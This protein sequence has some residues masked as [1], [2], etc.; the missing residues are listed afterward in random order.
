MESIDAQLFR[1]KDKIEWM[2][3]LREEGYVVI[4]DILDTE[5][6]VD[7]LNMFKKD[8]NTICPK[9]DFESTSTWDNNCEPLHSGWGVGMVNGHGFGQSD[10]QWKLRTHPN[11]LDIWKTVHNTD[12]LVV[13]YDGLSM[14]ISPYQ[15]GIMYHI[16][17]HPRDE[18]YSIQGAYNFFKVDTLDA[19]F[20]VVPKS[21]KT[22]TSSLPD[23]YNFIQINDEDEHLTRAKHLLIPQNCFVLWNSKTIH[24]SIGMCESRGV[25]LN[26]L[27]SYICYFPKSL[28]DEEVKQSRIDGYHNGDN[29]SHYAIYH[30]KKYNNGTEQKLKPTLDEDGC[31]PIDRLHLI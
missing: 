12:E 24:S 8:W 1:L 7:T 11:I 30:Q 5:Q 19:G 25:E 6:Y 10:C 18:L 21:H 20:V 4:K 23:T 15:N 14:F 17:Q 9:F 3:Y 28:R 13:S 26:R 31:I 29:C 22:Y 27:T 2:K 16:D